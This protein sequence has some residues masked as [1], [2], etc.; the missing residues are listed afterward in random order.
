MGNQ[1]LC[2]ESKLRCTENCTRISMGEHKEPMLDE[3]N[4]CDPA[5]TVFAENLDELNDIDRQL[6]LFSC[7]SNVIAVRW[8]LQLGANRFARDSNGTTCLHA[9]CRSGA[10]AIVDNFIRLDSDVPPGQGALS[11]VDIAGWTP[12][13]TAAFMGRHDVVTRLLQAGVPPEC[14][15]LSGQ[16]AGDLCND[17]RTRNLILAALAGQSGGR[18]VPPFRADVHHHF[19]DSMGGLIVEQVMPGGRLT[20]SKE[21]RFE[22]FFVPRTAVMKDIVKNPSLRRQLSAIGRTIFDKQ[23]GRGLAFLVATGC[24]RDYP[25]DLVGFLQGGSV[26][27]VQ[28][29]LFLGQDFSLSKI[30]RM[31]FINAIGFTNCGVVGCLK[32]AFASFRAPPDLQKVDRILGSLAEVWWRQHSK[33]LPNGVFPDLSSEEEALRQV[34]EAFAV[35]SL[36]NVG[37]IESSTPV[38]KEL[39]GF[40]VRRVVRS[41]AVMHQLMFSST[42]LHWNLHASLPRSSRISLAAWL[43][44]HRDIGSPHG[45][46]PDSVLTPIYHMVNNGEIPN[47]W[48]GGPQGDVRAPPASEMATLSEFASVKGWV[49]IMGDGL[50]TLLGSV[51]GNS[52]APATDCL[53]M[54]NMLSESTASS[55]RR[56]PAGPPGRSRSMSRPVDVASGDGKEREK[57]VQDMPRGPDAV[58]LSLCSPLL[59]LS[60]GPGSSRTPF[61]F[62]HLDA[63]K[64]TGIEP[65]KALFTVDGRPGTSDRG[66]EVPITSSITALQLVLLFPDGR[67]QHFHLPKLVVE[68][69]DRSQLESWVLHLN[70]ICGAAAPMMS[71]LSV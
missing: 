33:Y 7:G 32:K 26:D 4:H 10:P 8:L 59:F 57:R 40:E 19:T 52:T 51:G 2:S 71:P 53:H 62:I 56:P 66:D 67:W 14:K 36:V 35:Q 3:V 41:S 43:E 63:A 27:P 13:H 47:L 30:L 70:E 6:M 5:G 25:M 28:I 29:G 11:A 31:E 55:R 46:L 20:G 68:V 17:A 21:V 22:P 23:P 42:M 24:V 45:D 15:N 44:L 16:G 18:K 50:P 58:W 69:C 60:T 12:L 1:V 65:A 61:A 34:A 49:R 9:A 64:L 48:I 37:G 39:E 38:D 54:S